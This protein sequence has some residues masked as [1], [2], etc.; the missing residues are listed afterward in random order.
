MVRT[1]QNNKC[2]KFKEIIMEKSDGEA[3]SITLSAVS[4]HLN[5]CADCRNYEKS[6]INMAKLTSLMKVGM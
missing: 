6:L 4:K 2:L 5:E 3:D 1:M